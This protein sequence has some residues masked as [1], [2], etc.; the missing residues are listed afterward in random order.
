VTVFPI[1]GGEACPHVTLATNASRRGNCVVQPAAPSAFEARGASLSGG[2]FRPARS[3]VIPS[4]SAF[5]PFVTQGSADA[6]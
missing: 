2:V 3:F 1:A 4:L 6:P 5:P